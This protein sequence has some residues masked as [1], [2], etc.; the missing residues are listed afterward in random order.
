[1]T[2][3]LVVLMFGTV[4][5]IDYIRQ[6][7]RNEGLSHVGETL[8][9]ALEEAVPQ[10]VAGIRLPAPLY[11]HQ[12]HA[13]AHWV[14]PD[15]AFVGLDDFGRRLLGK[16]AQVE[17]PAVGTNLRQGKDFV[18]IRRNGDEVRLLAPITGEVVDVNP[19][20]KRNP[21][22]V[23]EDSYARGWLYKIRSPELFKELPNLL[24][25]SLAV[26]WMEDTFARFQHRMMLAS[27][28]V[29]QDGGGPVEDVAEQ[30]NHDQ[31]CSLVEEFM[32]SKP[33]RHGGHERG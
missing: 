9:R 2:V 12:G 32:L 23:H 15:Q 11:Y 14:T 18:A 30:L 29:I 1:M 26:R 27:G 31:W 22:L 6:R 24:R 21:E 13:W 5:L 28:S 17:L 7:K 10:T 3:I 33:T 20:L 25:G 19:E 4:I 8:Q 16:S